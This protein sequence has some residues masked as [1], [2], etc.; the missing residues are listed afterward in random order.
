M[1]GRTFPASSNTRRNASLTNRACSATCDSLLVPGS[2]LLTEIEVPDPDPP[3]ATAI[4]PVPGRFPVI[5]TR[6]VDVVV[7]V[8]EVAGL[9]EGEGACDCC[10]CC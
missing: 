9:G 5:E 4:D 2:L 7:V 10:C 3:P 1:E 8:V 6:R